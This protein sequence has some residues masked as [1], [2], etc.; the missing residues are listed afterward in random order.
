[1]TDSE[2]K[3]RTLQL[4]HGGRA[5]R[6][7]HSEEHPMQVPAVDPAAD[8]TLDSELIRGTREGDGNIADRSRASRGRG[9]GRGS[10]EG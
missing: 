1:M 6:H 10:R 9:R 2:S 5:R 3:G 8:V 7:V 4:D